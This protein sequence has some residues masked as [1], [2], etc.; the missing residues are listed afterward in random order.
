MNIL[1][2]PL[3]FALA[4]RAA[5]WPPGLTFVLALLPLCSLA[6]RLGM[7]TEQLA[8]YTNDSVG[9]LLNAT[10]GN[11]TEVIIAAFAISKG[12]LR[13]V[14]LTLLGSIVSNLLLVLGS[15]FIAGGVL[16]PM[17]HFNA[18][19][20]NVNCGLLILGVVAV[21]LPTLLSSTSNN[22]SDSGPEVALSRFESILM[23]V[24]Y[25]TFLLFQLI[26]EEEDEEEECVLSLWGA[27]VWLAGV[28]VLISFLSDAVMDSITAASTQL[29]V[30]LPFLTTIVVPIVGNAA[31][32]ASAL[33]FAVKDRM[34]VALGVAVGS[35]TQVA[36]LIVPFCV[37]LAWA[38]GQPLDMN[39]NEFEAAVL[40]ISVLLA[41]VVL[42]D[43]S[44]NYL[45]GL[46][47]VITY[48]FVAAGFWLHKDPELKEA[49]DAP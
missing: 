23:L 10:F 8:M 26:E 25:A 49:I 20:I 38:M 16:H 11:A 21:T 34:E 31:E 5:G 41:V 6:E 15:A 35:S 28:T 22:P 24:G 12:Y 32:H 3:P 42:Q 36:V 30:P 7:I 17:Q 4:G 40:F 45:K 43:G 27:L 46:M 44:S 39:F 18:K 33:I 14:K 48:F 19:G 1:L 13:V 37:I 29:K 47:L 2:L 9:G